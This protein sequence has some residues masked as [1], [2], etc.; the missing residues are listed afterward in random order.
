MKEFIFGD[1]VSADKKYIGKIIGLES[2]GK[3]IVEIELIE[4]T[5]WV[6][7]EESKLELL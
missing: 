2:E 7:F 4:S 6:V 3:Y 1:K 5:R